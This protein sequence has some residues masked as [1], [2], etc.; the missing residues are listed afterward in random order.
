MGNDIDIEKTEVILDPRKDV[1][2]ESVVNESTDDIGI[3]EQD[4]IL[5]VNND[6]IEGS[7]DKKS[8]NDNDVEKTEAILD[9]IEESAVNG[10]TDDMGIGEQDIILG[11]ENDAIEKNDVKESSN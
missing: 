9:I 2:E 7:D 8:I 3:E 11:V 1:I 10:Y 4:I 5:G 6:D